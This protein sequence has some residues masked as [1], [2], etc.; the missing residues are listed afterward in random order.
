MFV[1]F[2]VFRGISFAYAAVW[3]LM[4]GRVSDLS[5]GGVWDSRAYLKP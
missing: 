4:F 5:F 2:R 1:G 3:G